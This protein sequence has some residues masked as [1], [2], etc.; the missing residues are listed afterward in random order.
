MHQVRVILGI[1]PGSPFRTFMLGYYALMGVALVASLGLYLAGVNPLWSLIVLLPIAIAPIVVPVVALVSYS[2]LGG[3]RELLAGNGWARWEYSPQEWRDFAE[4]E[5]R[6]ARREARLGPFYTLILAAGFGGVVGFIAHDLGAALLMAGIIGV[7]GLV[8]SAGIWLAG[9]W[10]YRRRNAGAG[11][12]LVG[13]DGIYSRGQY[14]AFHAFNVRLQQVEVEPGDP[15]TLFVATS[16]HTEY[17]ATR[18][19]ETRVPIPAGREQEAAT[20][21]E[22]LRA[23]HLQP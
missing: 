7:A 13:P 16:S 17:G 3:M 12:V 21:A 11:A 18:S 4:A 10:R 23:L 6:R 15:A 9:R 14:T 8:T 1:V 20:I 19:Y 22:R 2:Y 5:W